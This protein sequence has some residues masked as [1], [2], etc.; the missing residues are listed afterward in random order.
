MMNQ[1]VHCFHDFGLSYL[2]RIKAMSWVT[3]DYL[4]WTIYVKINSRLYMCIKKANI[5]LPR[6]SNPLLSKWIRYCICISVFH[7]CIL[8]LKGDYKCWF[9]NVHQSLWSLNVLWIL[10]IMK[11]ILFTLKQSGWLESNPKL[12]TT[13]EDFKN[14][15]LQ[16][17]IGSF[18]NLQL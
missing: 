8:T 14:P 1:R 18:R 5:K 13:A 6:P 3:A 10:I 9:F 4:Q 16:L 15:N 2:Y 11:I 7:I 12:K 17:Q